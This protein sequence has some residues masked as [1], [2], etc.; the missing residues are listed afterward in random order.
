MD[1]WITAQTSLSNSKPHLN[2]A[3]LTTKKNKQHRCVGRADYTMFFGERDHIACH[4]VVLQAKKETTG[5]KLGQLL[6]YMHGLGKPF[7]KARGQSD[8]TVWGTL[9]DGQWLYFIRLSNAGQW[10]VVGYRITR[11][12]WG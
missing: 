7:G 1:S 11:D 10:S 3:R 4:L 6:A 2:G 9:T 12:G 8:S 5:A